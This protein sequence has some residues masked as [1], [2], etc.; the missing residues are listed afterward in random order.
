[1]QPG[2]QPVMPESRSVSSCLP[3]LPC[4]PRLPRLLCLQALALALAS[5]SPPSSAG[6]ATDGAGEH[7]DGPL[8]SDA[9]TSPPADAH[10]RPDA[11]A[12]ASP[13][14]IDASGSPARDASAG[15]DASAADGGAG[16]PGGTVACY[17]TSNPGAACTL[18]VHC[19]FT[20]YSSAH[21]GACATTACDWGTIDCDGPEDCASGQHCCANV[22]QDPDTGI[23]GYTL[24]CQSA[25][26]GA[27]PMHQEL[28]HPTSS[29]GGT[30]SGSGRSCVS[31]LGHDNDLPRAL[32]ICQ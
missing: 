19:C 17:T 9:R 28:C 31:A 18:P 8:A 25:A 26:C 29:P 27:A 7:D 5:C 16:V 22:I 21:D 11:A 14:P 12:D 13:L 23:L 3:C 6:Q 32:S 20:D 1:M 15:S 30:C 4:L 24:A 2:Q 10:G